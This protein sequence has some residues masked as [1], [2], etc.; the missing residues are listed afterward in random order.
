V[1][2]R[3]AL[4]LCRA[5]KFLH[6]LG[7]LNLDL[8]GNNVL[9]S[10]STDRIPIIDFGPAHCRE[11]ESVL[12]GVSEQTVLLFARSVRV[13]NTTKVHNE[14]R[15]LFVVVLTMSHRRTSAGR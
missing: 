2:L 5:L 4:Q 15:H 7:V 9:Y 8:K 14:N 13:F 3:V 1:R 12:R 6:E 10:V 11:R